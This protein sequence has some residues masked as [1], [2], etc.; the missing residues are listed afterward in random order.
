M[1]NDIARVVITK[2]SALPSERE[3]AKKLNLSFMQGELQNPDGGKIR[4]VSAPTGSGKSF[5]FNLMVAKEKKKVLFLAPTRRLAE[6]LCKAARVEMAKE[7]ESTGCDKQVAREIAED[8][9]SVMHGEKAQQIREEAEAAARMDGGERTKKEIY[10]EVFQWKKGQIDRGS[11]FQG[12]VTFATPEVVAALCFPKKIAGETSWGLMSFLGCCDHIVMDEYHLLT[13]GGM[14]FMVAFARAKKNAEK[15]GEDGEFATLNF[16]SATPTDIAPLLKKAG[17][18]RSEITFIQEKV[19]EGEVS[20]ARVLHGDVE[21]VFEKADSLSELVGRYPEEVR[22]EVK[23]R[24]QVA[25][26]HD[27]LSDIMKD[28]GHEWRR[29]QKDIGIDP[30]NVLV[31]NSADDSR[32]GPPSQDAA[33]FLSGSCFDSTGEAVQLV[34]ATSSVEAGVS[35]RNNALIFMEPGQKELNFLQRYGRCARGAI[36][37]KVVVRWNEKSP[38][39]IRRL[40]GEVQEAASNGITQWS[41]NDLSS[42]LTMER[43]PLAAKDGWMSVPEEKGNDTNLD[44]EELEF[45]IFGVAKH[46]ATCRAAAWDA[47][48]MLHLDIEGF[49]KSHEGHKRATQGISKHAW[50]IAAELKSIF[51]VGLKNPHLAKG[52]IVDRMEKALKKIEKIDK[53]LAMGT[54]KGLFN[55]GRAYFKEAQSLRDFEEKVRVQE[56]GVFREWS[57]SQLNRTRFFDE[58]GAVVMED[59]KGLFLKTTKN[60][61][62]FFRGKAKKYNEA[63]WEAKALLPWGSNEEAKFSTKK[64]EFGIASYKRLLIAEGKKMDTEKGSDEAFEE[65]AEICAQLCE[66]GGVGPF[67]VSDEKDAPAWADALTTVL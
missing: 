25:V 57:F 34:L 54:R 23:N 56:N 59:E 32:K 38:A 60:V 12:W 62:A 15:N 36:N 37:G 49:S 18:E 61:E 52:G 41:I 44:R 58:S 29:I 3:E 65:I 53:A 30:C 63:D 42:R 14:G 43:V 26:I 64:E 47:M 13:E 20:G 5:A 19:V 35:F 24:R 51:A 40:I 55:W 48:L 4:I 21:L 6:N 1:K 9:C 67:R 39:W 11:K 17:I 7:L 27:R 16:L 22:E 8:R 50:A 31:I 45:Q 2:H 66:K 10:N 46:E 33:D 28:K